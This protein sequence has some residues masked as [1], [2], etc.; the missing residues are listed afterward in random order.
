MR[1]RRRGRGR[2]RRRGGFRRGRSRRFG[3]RRLRVGFRM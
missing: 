1:F 2:H 3:G